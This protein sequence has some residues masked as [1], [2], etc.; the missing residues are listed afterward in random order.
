MP[1]W[2]E[3]IALILASLPRAQKRLVTLGADAVF[4]P[5]ALWC[6]IALHFNGSQY[7]IE[8]VNWLYGVALATAIPIFARLGLYRAVIRFLGGRALFAVTVGV[9][10]SVLLLLATNL[11][12]MHASVPKPV[13]VVY[14]AFAL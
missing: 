5:F 10:A 12:I 7:S 6:A 11:A 14:W 4:I 3:R 8:G 1:E 2:I 9:T 13:F